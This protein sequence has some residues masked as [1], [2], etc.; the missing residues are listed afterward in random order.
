MTATA[1]DP[2]LSMTC[3]PLKITSS[4][5]GGKIGEPA[6][7]RPSALPELLQINIAHELELQSPA[8]VAVSYLFLDII[9]I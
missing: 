1:F 7:T 5:L 9:S 2:S 6:G 4:G 8:Q 3:A